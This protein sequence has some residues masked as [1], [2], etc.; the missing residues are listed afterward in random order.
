VK[1]NILAGK[2][3][4][5]FL[6]ELQP[7]FSAQRTDEIKHKYWREGRG[8]VIYQI[9]SCF[10]NVKSTNSDTVF[11]HPNNANRYSN[12]RCVLYLPPCQVSQLRN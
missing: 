9:I 3:R 10:E 5:R 8:G 6:T 2:K 11:L 7:A 4:V 1:S 12:M